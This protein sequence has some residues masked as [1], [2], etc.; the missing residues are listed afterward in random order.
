MAS[1]VPSLGQ[2]SGRNYMKGVVGNAYSRP[3]FSNSSFQREQQVKTK[4]GQR[5]FDNSPNGTSLPRT[6]TPGSCHKRQFSNGGFQAGAPPQPHPLSL[7][8]P[9]LVQ[10]PWGTSAPASTSVKH[11]GVGHAAP[12]QGWQ[13]QYDSGLHKA[14]NCNP[15]ANQPRAREAQSVRELM[16]PSMSPPVSPTPRTRRPLE[17]QV[18][19]WQGGQDSTILAR[20]L[21]R[22]T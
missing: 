16:Y 3:Q 9:S 4:Q 5:I 22:G 11:C 2:D 21:A 18:Q 7:A 19:D 1:V 15:G 12:P 10:P 14:R 8:T 13:G 17:S 6:Y 20:R